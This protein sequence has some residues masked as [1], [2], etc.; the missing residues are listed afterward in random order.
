MLRRSK[1]YGDKIALPTW[2]Y[3]WYLLNA[4][5][6]E[7]QGK[8][9]QALDLLSEAKKYYSKNPIPNIEPLDTLKTRVLI[10][11]GKLISSIDWMQERGLS[12]E[13][14]IVYIHE[15][16]YMILARI[17]ISEFSHTHNEKTLQ[18]VKLLIERLLK[19]AQK[20]NSIGRVIE[21]FILQ[22]IVHETNDDKILAVKSLK[23]AILLAEPEQHFQVFVDEGERLHQLLNESD[24][25]K[26]KPDYISKLLAV[27]EKKK[28]TNEY[29]ETPT[30]FVQG[31]IEPLSERELVML[32]LIS[33]G[34]SNREICDKLFLALSTVKGYNQNLYS[35]LRVKSRTEAIVRAHEL[36]LL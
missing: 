29:R 3:N 13:D 28:A 15:S 16:E 36:K 22:A 14:E 30:T 31:V 10:R 2:R 24:I 1:E 19:E 27:I 11:Q 26:I 18:Q 23:Q 8:L 21:I 35:K 6:K 17:L 32:Q 34:L 9:N 33:Q 20:G 5:I 25:R 7:S 12:I 4:K